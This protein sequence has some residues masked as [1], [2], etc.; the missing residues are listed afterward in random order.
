MA[1]HQNLPELCSSE[2]HTRRGVFCSTETI[3]SKAKKKTTQPC[4]DGKTSHLHGATLV[5]AG[6]MQGTESLCHA[7]MH[8]FARLLKRDVHRAGCLSHRLGAIRQLYTQQC[9]RCHKS[10]GT[11][12]NLKCCCRCAEGPFSYSLWG[13]LL[14]KVA[15]PLLHLKLLISSLPYSAQ[16]PAPRSA[17]PAC[18]Q[19]V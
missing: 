6:K 13:I 1:G 3:P 2:L 5:V 12:C 19:C 17:H 9:T 10:G 14:Q 8:I 16:T 18:C 7:V 11:Y 4:N 15:C